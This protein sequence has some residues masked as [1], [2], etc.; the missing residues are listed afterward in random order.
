MWTTWVLW[1]HWCTHHSSTSLLISVVIGR[2]DGPSIHTALSCARVALTDL[3]WDIE[4]PLLV[5]NLVLGLLHNSIRSLA[6]DHS[7]LLLLLRS[8]SVANL[9]IYYSFFFFDF[10]NNFAGIYGLTF[11]D[12]FCIRLFKSIVLPCHVV[13]VVLWVA[14]TD[15]SLIL[16]AFSLRLLH[17]A[18]HC[19]ACLLRHPDH[20]THGNSSALAEL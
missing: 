18:F 13:H 15:F 16:E 8:C 5:V 20:P 2:A 4:T 6:W 3:S 11:L 17:T 10:L 1:C 14:V 7:A 19:D 9:L 12:L